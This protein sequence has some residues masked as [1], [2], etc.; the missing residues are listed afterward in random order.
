MILTKEILNYRETIGRRLSTHIFQILAILRKNKVHIDRDVF[1][2]YKSLIFAKTFIGANTGITGKIVIKG[3]AEVLIGRFCA[4]G[5][6]IK[7][8]THN[9]KINSANLQI[10]LARKEF[11]QNLIDTN[12]GGVKIGNNVWIG[13]SAIILPGVNIGHGA[14]I[15]AGSIVTKSV[16]AFSVYAGNPARL[17]KHRFSEKVIKQL[18]EINWWDWSYE[19]IKKNKAFFLADLI[20]NPNIDLNSIIVK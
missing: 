11:K 20:E 1:L 3:E 12:K 13:D 19:K 7:I 6:D 15:G 9:H 14:V 17:I 5:S 16:P 2:S 8:I 10:S 4:L 18:L